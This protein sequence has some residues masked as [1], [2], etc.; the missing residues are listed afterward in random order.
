MLV[1]EIV[2]VVV[3][4]DLVQGWPLLLCGLTVFDVRGHR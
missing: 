2:V 4:E 3:V 1:I